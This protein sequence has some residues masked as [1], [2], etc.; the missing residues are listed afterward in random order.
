MR[1]LPKRRIVDYPRVDR[2][3]VLAHR[4]R[5]LQ[6]ELFA[7]G[8]VRVAGGVLGVDG[9]LEFAAAAADLG[10]LIFQTHPGAAGAALRKNRLG[11]L[12]FQGPSLLGKRLGFGVE[13]AGF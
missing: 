9:E 4:F 8:G 2:W 11:H 5:A 7:E 3:G 12:G 13:G 10:A 1:G 6:P